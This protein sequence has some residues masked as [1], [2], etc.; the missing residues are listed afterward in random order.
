MTQKAT[1]YARVSSRAQASEGHGLSS[2][3]ARCRDFAAS[4]GWEVV[5]TFPDPISGGI[6]FMQR[7]G[8]VALLS[9]LD[10]QPDEN[11]TVIFDDPKRFARSTRFHIDLREALR[12]RG[13][14]IACLNFKF[15]DSPE[16]EFIETIIVAQGELERKQNGRQ[17]GQKM[18]ARMESG[19]WIHT[20]PLGYRY[21][22]VKGR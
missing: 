9:F 4:K 15:D 1:I 19:Y 22:T 21:V 17:V 2:Q 3:E 6:D 18:Q 8:M 11:F 14:Q 16:G 7:S 20:A 12:Q 10:A 5:A 13:A